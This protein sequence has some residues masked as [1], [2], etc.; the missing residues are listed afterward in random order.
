MIPK[1]REHNAVTREHND[2]ENNR[3]QHCHKQEQTMLPKTAELCL[4]A[5]A[6]VQIAVC[7]LA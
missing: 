5:V 6:A 7:G 3:T 2:T 1:T 4:A